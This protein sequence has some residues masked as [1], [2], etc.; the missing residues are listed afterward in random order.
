MCLSSICR[1]WL[2]KHHSSSEWWM[3]TVSIVQ[4][5]MCIRFTYR[6]SSFDCE[7]NSTDETWSPL[8]CSLVC[9][10]DRRERRQRVISGD[11]S[12]QIS[13]RAVVS[14]LFAQIPIPISH[15]L[16]L[17]LAFKIPSYFAKRNI[18]ES[19]AGT[20]TGTFICPLHNRVLTLHFKTCQHTQA[21]NL[22]RSSVHGWDT[23]SQVP[24]T[25]TSDYIRAT[26]TYNFCQLYNDK[27][28]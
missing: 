2:S 22:Q 3:N 7:P 10:Q 24:A 25:N 14:S 19:K 26:C 6:S 9:E 11:V 27:S 15:S 13:I 8:L 18:R 20:G 5:G 4:V 12:K 23:M 1:A 16:L 17:H 21:T 28:V